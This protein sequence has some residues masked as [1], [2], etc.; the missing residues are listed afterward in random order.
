MESR[1]SL[2]IGPFLYHAEKLNNLTELVI[3]NQK[4]K[5]SDFLFLANSECQG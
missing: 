2:W 1:V 4:V 3:K 5:G